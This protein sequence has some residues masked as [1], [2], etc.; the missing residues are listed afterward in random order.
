MRN[1]IILVGLVLSLTFL[2]A[3]TT[4]FEIG[5]VNDRLKVLENGE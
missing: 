1:D 2:L 4:M 5:K 3:L